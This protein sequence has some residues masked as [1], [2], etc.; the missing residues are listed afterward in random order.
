MSIDVL[1]VSSKGQV[2]LPAEMRKQLSISSG[3]KLAAYASG[4]II[5]L[6]VIK[7]PSEEDFIAHMD[8]AK[9]WAESVGYQQDDINSIIKDV[10]KRKHA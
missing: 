4:D 2:V 6:K 1:T 8:E 3:D 9:S 10:R 7:M 5:M